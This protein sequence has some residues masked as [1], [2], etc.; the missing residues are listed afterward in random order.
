[1]TQSGSLLLVFGAVMAGLALLL[2]FAAIRLGVASRR[3]RERDEGAEAL[4]M[5]AAVEQL[6]TRLREQ[7]RD[8]QARA[9]ASERLSHEIVAGLA[10]GLL[11]VGVAGDVRILNPAGRQLLGLDEVGAG[12]SYDTLLEARAAPLASVIS[13]CLSTRRPITRRAVTLLRAGDG[14]TPGYLGVSVSPLRDEQGAPRGAICLFTD[15]SEVV[16]LED[17]LH[18]QDSLARVGELTAGL[19]HEFRNGLATIHGYGRLIDPE[20]VLPRYRPYVE[21]IRQETAALREVVDRFLDFARPAELSL[22]SL[23]LDEVVR[24]AVDDVRRDLEEHWG[25]VRVEGTFG[26]VEGDEVL[27]RQ[28]FSNLCRNAI[29]ACRHAGCVPRLTVGGAV[30]ES[31]GLT[32]VSVIDNGPGIDPETKTRVFQPF[33]TTKE[34]GT[35]LGLAL[36][37]KIIV[38]HNGRVTVHE[39]SGGGTRFEVVLPLALPAS[40][41]ETVSP[42]H[43]GR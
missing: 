4:F 25:Q 32:T 7:E 29:E 12:L 20:Q 40:D 18:L 43:P 11:V 36:T 31:R 10:S 9:E 8:S 22:A 27:L 23:G 1:M 3:A 42:F 13:E 21:G 14:A 30:D 5:T 19:A 37:Q 16:E 15:L 6:V 39:A 33:F 17:R 38:T 41:T 2:V 35:G 26:A 28:A 24:R 34:A